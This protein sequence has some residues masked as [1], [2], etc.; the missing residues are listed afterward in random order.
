MPRI[1]LILSD[2]DDTIM[3]RGAARVSDRTRAA[4][5]TAR[6]AGIVVGPASGR[7]FAQISPFFSGD[8]A[9]F[10]T[11]IATNGL[12]VY[13]GGARIAAQY[14]PRE[15]L[16]QT[17]DVLNDIPRAG[18]ICFDGAH[19]LLVAGERVDLAERM[20]GYE[21]ACDVVGALPDWPIIKANAFM[22]GD[23]L[24][25]EEFCSRL[26]NA[27]SALDFDIPLP[28][29][30]NIMPAGWNKGSA[31]TYL[32]DRLG[33][34]LNEVVVF[35]DAGNDL[36]MFDAVENAV[37]VANATPEAAAAARWH[38]GACADDAVAQIIERVAAGEW[39]F[40]R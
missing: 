31:V 15:A 9:C 36:T 1:K 13:H 37:A 25:T 5:H 19:P 16:E 3:P 11:C 26:N 22:A 18:L 38:I 27:V 23:A 39:P 6:E 12:E 32:C 24:T 17:L 4:F 21:E 33:I 10:S 34:G 40:V 2:I 30:L 35:G 7:G 14:L 20:P 28:G 8:T 29:Y